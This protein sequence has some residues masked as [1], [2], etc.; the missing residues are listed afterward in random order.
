MIFRIQIMA[1]RGSEWRKWD[2]HVHTKGTNKNDQFSS[3]S[4]E[5]FFELFFKK[6]VVNDIS[7]IGI[8]DY[9]T[10]DNYLKAK[11]YVSLIETKVNDLGE[12]LFNDSEINFIKNIF[13]FPNVEL[14]MMPSTGIEKL[15]NIHC[16]FNPDYVTELDNDFFN[17][18]GNQDR[19]KMNRAGFISYGKSLKP[20]VTDENLLFKEGI[21]NFVIDP[22]SVKE[23]IDKNSN[24]KNNTIIVVSN[25]SN[26]GN[27][28][29]Q[30]HYDLFEGEQ[31]SL[32]GV[33]RTI[34]NISNAIFSTNPKD[35]KY[36]LG[37]RLNDNVDVTE[38]EKSNE[39]EQVIL[40]RG[41]LKPCLVGSDA[42]KEEDLFNRFTWIKS[43][44][45]L[46][47]PT[48]PLFR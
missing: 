43:N 15:I 1:N 2:L 13:I 38:L 45:N 44:L 25:S 34:Y 16:I 22:K 28:G 47:L 3:N 5:S 12:K 42:H 29:L 8:T 37:K 9:F 40:E 27:S 39:R 35:V 21:N 48:N 7:A 26:D 36:F 46:V 41:S 32:D 11:L 24:L 17:E 10:I 33:R 14:R 30:K 20:N 18:I 31:S 6:A 23:L 19:Y 4:T